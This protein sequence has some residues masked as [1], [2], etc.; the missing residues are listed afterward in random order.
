[1]RSQPPA[2]DISGVSEYVRTKG[3]RSM[4]RVLCVEDDPIVRT[5]LSE[6]LAMENDIQVT[7]AVADAGTACT[8]LREDDVDV[9]VLDQQLAASEGL[10][11][12]RAISF[13]YAGD[14][15]RRKPAV[16]FCTGLADAQFEEKAA[17][18]GA[19]GVV[20]KSRVGADLIPA[21]RSI[22]E[23]GRW[24]PITGGHVTEAR[25]PQR[26]S[27]LAAEHRRPLRNSLE[28]MVASL[29]CSLTLAWRSEE[30][31][32]ELTARRYHALLLGQALPGSMRITELLE[33]IAFRWPRLPVFLLTNQRLL[34]H[35]SP[36]P[37]VRCVLAVPIDRTRLREEIWEALTNPPA[38]PGHPHV[39]VVSGMR[40]LGLR[41]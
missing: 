13:W 22:A 12:L 29:E 14:T 2:S 16:V 5:F 20:S 21:V 38:V 39:P 36:A 4:I 27:V 32:P 25:E 18:L 28:E 8:S 10:D 1:M 34:E 17:R 30:I 33:E 31:I 15:T 37:N 3:W 7:G 26:W 40:T 23:G 19:A 41:N 35:Y 6:R 11:L 24:Y 9:V